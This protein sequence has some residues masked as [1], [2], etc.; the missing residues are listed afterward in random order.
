MGAP[1]RLPRLREEIA[2]SAGP[3]LP[4]GQPSWTLHDPVRNLYYQIDWPTFEI[5]ARWS[6]DDAP[7]IVAAVNR[8]TTLHLSADDVAAVLRFLGEHQLLAPPA[9]SAREFAQRLQLRRGSPL[10]WLLHHYLFFRIPLVRP[11]AWLTRIAPRLDFFFS[12]RFLYLSLAALLVGALG[13]YR[14]WPQF[15][16]SLVDLFTWQGVVA[17]GLTIA[18]VKTLHELGHA[19][20]AKRHGCHVPTMGI[21]F[22]VMWPVAYTDTN[23]VW[24][25]SGRKER[26]QVAAA[27][28]V[29]ELTIAA[30]ASLTWAWLPE[31]GPRTVAFLL[32]S[33][34]WISTLAI[35]ASPFMRFDG[36]FLLSD[37]L[38]LPNLHTRAFALARWDLRERLFAL[39]EEYPEYFPPRRRVGLIAF[40]WLTWAY[41]L[42]VFLGIAAL[43]YHFFF[44]AIGILLFLVEIG[45]FVF[46][47]L[48]QE[49]QVWRQ[50]WQT[51]RNSPR[52]RR[53]GL[54]GAVLALFFILPWPSRVTTSGLLQPVAQLAIYAPA[55]AHLQNWPSADS[56]RVDAATTP[57]VMTSPLLE[58]QQRQNAARREGLSWQSAAAGFDPQGRGDWQVL[59]ERLSTAV[60]EGE[61][62]AAD[63]VHYAPPMPFAGRLVDTDPD[64]RPG[65][66]LGERE[67]LAR[68]V[69]DGAYQ[70]VT[71]VDDEEVQRVAVGDR[72]LFVGNGGATPIVHLRVERID[73]DASQTLPEAELAAPYG[74]HVQVRDKNSVLYPERP[75]Y[76]VLLAVEGDD[77]ALPQHSWRGSVAI[78]ATWE[79]PGM[80]YLRAILRALWRESG[81]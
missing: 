60:A 67:F 15:S 29:T 19:V 79:A 4:D 33:T 76:R 75:A 2:L 38:R 49:I 45:W 35:N 27:G 21:A 54:A 72:A 1:H 41:R 62:V 17:Y 57:I 23:D 32:A 66:W 12:P 47:P 73:H 51:I 40:A 46:G 77:T 65:D 34:T 26:L 18:I 42:F 16:T 71:Y 3:P 14:D 10:R 36:Y 55:H 9:G 52:A 44:K 59:D 63:A 68:L 24:R 8:E 58:L 11:D 30:W 69:A 28:I 64:L 5:L 53:N 22:L 48:W 70:V 56:V 78:A 7:A 31:G 13:I 43:V 25:L 50:H 6:F 81:F 20:T 74:G 61:T 37:F 80:R 39:G